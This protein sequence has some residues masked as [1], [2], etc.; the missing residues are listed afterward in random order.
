MQQI[1]LGPT[2][3]TQGTGIDLL[4]FAGSQ[5][6]VESTEFSE[7][8]DLSIEA[9]EEPQQEI[10]VINNYVSESLDQL[11]EDSKNAEP[12]TENDVD[13]ALAQSFAILNTVDSII[14]GVD[15][16]NSVEDLKSQLEEKGVSEE[17]VHKII[18]KLDLET[19]T[20]ET[21]VV[22]ADVAST[23]KTPDLEQSKTDAMIQQQAA[24][25]LSMTSQQ[26]NN[27][28]MAE[29]I[30]S[31]EEIIDLSVNKKQE[32]KPQN[33]ISEFETVEK[34]LPLSEIP[35]PTDKVDNSK[36]KMQELVSQFKANKNEN[37]KLDLA[38]TTKPVVKEQAQ[39]VQPNITKTTPP[40]ELTEPL[41]T[42][43][44]PTELA[45]K[46]KLG[47]T[48]TASTEETTEEVSEYKALQ[49]KTQEDT[50]AS[51]TETRS[52]KDFTQLEKNISVNN[53]AETNQIQTAN[54]EMAQKF[55]TMIQEKVAIPQNSN[56]DLYK[57][58]QE[59]NVQSQINIA[60]KQ[61][62]TTGDRQI[63]VK[64]HPEEL[65]SIDIE[66]NISESSARGLI[67]V[68]SPEVAKHLAQNLKEAF[69][70]FKGA[71][72]ELSEK[73]IEIKVDDNASNNKR[74]QQ[75]SDSRQEK[76]SQEEA[77]LSYVHDDDSLDIKV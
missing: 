21:P 64:L 55:D 15:D 56:L 3:G 16:L 10:D 68:E 69:Q 7:T 9:S 57:I 70:G 22:L 26:Q 30:N 65:G 19:T 75:N 49:N 76:P 50:Q 12:T 28:I 6:D 5:E 60:I 40:T 67:V 71:G 29:Q 25:M 32:I 24:K 72:F 18:E 58:A 1:D 39:T 54:V 35:K 13:M 41:K 52:N 20:Q 47:N 73:D 36:T 8:L 63:K 2:N 33:N 43:A 31:G 34:E 11:D 38:Q 42:T 77:I 37:E 45:V 4:A 17:N 51:N 62:K 48:K 14:S 59:A 23:T 66:L 27:N 44:H 74:N 53:K 46:Q 61:L